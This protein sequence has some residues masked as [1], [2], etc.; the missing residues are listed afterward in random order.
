[1]SNL[2][3]SKS[4]HLST[5]FVASPEGISAVWAIFR[6]MSICYLLYIK[7]GVRVNRKRL[8]SLG[9]QLVATYGIR[10]SDP[11]EQKRIPIPFPIWDRI[12]S[13]EAIKNVGRALAFFC[14]IGPT[15]VSKS[16]RHRLI[17]KSSFPLE[18]LL[19]SP[20]RDDPLL[21]LLVRTRT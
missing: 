19:N 11:T 16:H 5:C 7:A 1:M 12:R 10:W 13:A 14:P 21:F 4:K 18:I 17:F 6:P 8:A 2:L 9:S 3:F 15:W 20:I